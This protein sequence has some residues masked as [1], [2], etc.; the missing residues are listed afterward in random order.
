M[1]GAAAD[2][3]EEPPASLDEVS[4]R[5]APSHDGP[6]PPGVFRAEFAPEAAP[7]DDSSPDV[8]GTTALPPDLLA[9][10]KDRQL[11]ALGQE[12]PAIRFVLNHVRQLD[13]E[14]MAA[15]A[16]ENVAFTVLMVRPDD[17]RGRLLKFNGTLRQLQPFVAPGGD[18][19]GADV[20]EGWMFSATSDNNPYRVLVTEIPADLAPGDDLEIPVEFT[21]YFIKQYGYLTQDGDHV[22]P[23]LIGKTFR[24]RPRPAAAD[25]AIGE[26][27]SRFVLGF[28]LAIGLV[29]A[30][31]LWRFVV[32]DR[33]FR[34][35]RMQQL[36]EARLEARDEDISAIADLDIL[37][38]ER[39]FDNLE[40]S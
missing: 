21:G 27:L 3:G 38:P 11:G 35:S 7:V 24:L 19:M 28:L 13:Q 15:A 29:L 20:Y 5:A 22:A 16:V 25:P 10:V 6:L 30:L 40:E 39:M 17:Y 32:S 23:M 12:Q 33:R 26:D 34:D 31:L 1:R 9:D 4:F 37:D 8:P 36:A 14:A 18:D 2:E